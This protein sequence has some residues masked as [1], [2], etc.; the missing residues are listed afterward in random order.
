MNKIELTEEQ[1]REAFDKAK[2][3][4][5]KKTLTALFP[6]IA[7]ELTKKK[8]TLDD[9]ASITSYD[10]ACEALEECSWLNSFDGD[11]HNADGDY[12]LTVPPHIVAL[13]KLETISRA[14]WGRNWR[15]K[16]DAEGSKMF[17]WPWFYL[18]TKKEVERMSIQQ[19]MLLLSPLRV[20]GRMPG[21][22]LWMRMVAP[23]TRVC[24]LGSACA[25]KRRRRQSTSVDGTSSNYGLNT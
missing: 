18:Y 8:P 23:Q 1:V 9:Y 24:T 6:A 16:P 7:K 5:V 20:L 2:S 12:I 4:E 25:K 11:V 17:Y 19:T 22:V 21:S 15:P 13:M 10:D 14:L 3:D